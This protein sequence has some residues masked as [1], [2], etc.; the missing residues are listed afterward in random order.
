MPSPGCPRSSSHV[1]A[2]HLDDGL[3]FVEIGRRL[4]KTADAARMVYNRAL[5]RLQSLLPPR[6]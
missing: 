3:S 5:E 1:L 4:G 6:G 2:L